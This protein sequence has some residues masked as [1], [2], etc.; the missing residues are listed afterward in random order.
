MKIKKFIKVVTAFIAVLFAVYLLISIV[1]TQIVLA[2]V[3]SFGLAVS[4]SDRIAATLHDIVGLAEMLPWLIVPALLVAFIVAALGKRFM[5][6]NRTYWYLAAGLTSLPAGL[7]LLELVLGGAPY[8]AARTGFGLSLIALCGMAG[9]W[10]FA[11]LT[12]KRGALN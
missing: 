7:I 9:W 1:W 11:R 2:E 3:K 6:G 8:A 10:L 4:L 12:Q 5:G